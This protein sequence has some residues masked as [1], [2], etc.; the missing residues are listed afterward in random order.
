MKMY[1]VACIAGLIVGVLYSLVHIRSPAPPLIAL[2]GLGSI[3]AGEQ[4]I[5]L[6]RKVWAGAPLHVAW[7]SSGSHSS[8]LGPL[9]GP[10]AD[11]AAPPVS[12]P[13]QNGTDT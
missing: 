11:A 5:P 9:P 12:A 3:L 13:D 4:I 2:I 6:A 10:L 1:L 7:H 8:V